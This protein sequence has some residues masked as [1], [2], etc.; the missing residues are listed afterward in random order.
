MQKLFEKIQTKLE[1]YRPIPFWSWND[2]LEKEVMTWQIKEMAKVGCGG[3]FMHARGG[4]QTDY[5]GEEWFEKIELGIQEGIKAD[6]HPWVYDE[7]GWPS[8]FASGKV[9]AKGELYHA[10]GL[11]LDEIEDLASYQKDKYFLGFYVLMEENGQLQ[12]INEEQK[13]GNYQ[14]AHTKLFAMRYTVCPD[15]ID[16]LNKEVVRYFIECTHEEYY[17]RFKENFGKGLEGFFTD[18]PRISEGSVPWSH[19]LPEEFERRYGYNL[20]E[21]LPALF[22]RCKGYAKVRYDFWRM[23]SDLFVKAFMKQIY[24]W[25]EDHNCQLTGHVMMEESIYSQM[26]GTAGSMPF[27]EYMHIPGI[28]WLRRTIGN[29]IIAKQVASVAE[30][31]GKTKVLTESYALCGWNVTLE[32][33]KWIAEWQFVNG[34]N[35]MC[36]HLEGYTLRG[37]RKRDYPPSLFVQQTWWEEYKTFNDY[38]ARLGALL[39]EGT[40]RV[41]TLVLHPMQSGWI[42]YDGTNNEEVKKLDKDLITLTDY[43]IEEHIDYHF[44]DETLL[45]KYAKVEGNTFRVGNGCYHNVII[46]SSYTLKNHTVTLIEEFIERGGVVISAGEFPM[47]CEGE[48]DWRLKKLSKVIQTLS[49][50]EGLSARIKRADTQAVYIRANQQE[51]GAIRYTERNTEEGRV[52]FLANLSKEKNYSTQ[53]T[54]KGCYKVDYL[55]LEKMETRPCKITYALENTEVE[56]SFAPMQSYLLIAKEVEEVMQLEQETESVYC[57]DM[58]QTDWSVKNM[59]LNAL[60]LDKCRYRIDK[61][62]WQEEVPVIHLMKHLLALKRPCQV[63]MDF[64]FEIHASLEKI[65]SFY[66]I[67]EEAEAFQITINDHVIAYKE[68]GWWKDTAFKKVTIRPFLKKGKNHIYMKR[69]FYQSPHVYHVLFDEGVYE[70]EFNQLTYDVELESIYLLGDFGVISEGAYEILERDGLRTAGPFKI[71]E[72]PK[73]LKGGDFTSQGLCFFSGKLH[74]ECNLKINKEEGGA[75]YLDFGR[76]KAPLFKLF[77]NG[78][79]VD[80]KLWAPFKVDITAYVKKGI[81]QVGIELYSSNRNLLGPHHHINGEIY[82]VGPLSFSGEWSWCERPT[83]GVEIQEVDRSRSYWRDDYCFVKFGI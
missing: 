46:P 66:L 71:V 75:I 13:K 37:L 23:I 38:L 48:P 11:V 47:L 19:L 39:T 79:Y 44:G 30:Q 15:Y 33:L 8:G 25:C 81:N 43:L 59:D 45:E 80:K 29:S 22:I 68:E 36:Q 54:L 78:E 21:Q 5:L 14:K 83:E 28:D 42:S 72:E 16:I 1:T 63:E 2:K 51:I 64:S 24:D 77:I 67:A 40:K 53:V 18:E 52:L 55:D 65:E 27:Y 57:M 50:K 9:T 56:L 26:T 82:N 35:L 62:E 69:F 49:H 17:K 60:T 10:K 74:L 73:M 61:G 6:V 7:C 34:V 32:E 41:D 31:L 3:Y 4:I 20:V 76:I 12:K 58:Q 70:T